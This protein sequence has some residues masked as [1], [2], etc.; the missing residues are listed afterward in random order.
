MR[1]YVRKEQVEESEIKFT[2][3]KVQN[4]VKVKS[5][6]KEDLNTSYDNGENISTPN[7]FLNIR[8]V[9][10][11]TSDIFMFSKFLNSVPPSYYHTTHITP[12]HSLPL[13]SL[14]FIL[15]PPLMIST[16][17]Q[18]ILFSPVSSSFLKTNH[19]TLWILPLKYP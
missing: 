8:S 7:L 2:C 13:T 6:K 1:L 10:S 14:L 3:I 11:M 16:V 5:T 4:E 17:S 15:Q 19:Q 18:V 12:P 9:L